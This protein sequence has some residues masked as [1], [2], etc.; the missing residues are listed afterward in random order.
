MAADFLSSWVPDGGTG[1]EFVFDGL[2]ALDRDAV[3]DSGAQRRIPSADTGDNGEW[4]TSGLADTRTVTI[5]GT[6]TAESAEELRDAIDTLAAT[7]STRT[8]GRLYIHSDRFLLCRISRFDYDPENGFNWRQWRATFKA[9]GAPFWQDKLEVGYDNVAD[10]IDYPAKGSV[11]YPAK[12]LVSV[13]SSG[14]PAGTITF[15]HAGGDAILRPSTTGYFL[16]DGVAGTVVH[17]GLVDEDKI[18][19][20]EGIF[21]TADPAGGTIEITNISGANYTFA[22]FLTQGRYESL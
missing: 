2:Y 19:D 6:I 12:I 22:T 4:A 15:T 20:F 11:P 3:T 13:S 5:S 16:I 18:A 9:S 10:E 17:Q 21:P 8:E 1:T 7:F 14:T